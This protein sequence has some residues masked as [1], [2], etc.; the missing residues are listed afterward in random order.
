M[1][2]ISQSVIDKIKE[3]KITP[4]PRWGFLARNIS[5]WIFFAIS[6]IIGS[7]G[8]SALV[9]IMGISDWSVFGRLDGN[10]L[11]I[12]L[13]SMPYFWLVF[14]AVFLGAAY[15]NIFHTKTGY[16]YSMR[17]VAGLIAI[18]VTATGLMLYFLGGG[19]AVDNAF[20]ENIPAY[21]KMFFGQRILWMQPDKGLLAGEVKSM[22]SEKIFSLEDFDGID[23]KI[24]ITEDTEFFGGAEVGEGARL[25][26]VGA[27]KEPGVFEVTEIR[28]WMH[29][30]GC[31][32]HKMIGQCAM[33]K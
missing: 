31:R 22:E 20:S 15:F 2:D 27:K 26:L 19:K 29:G 10:Y 33:E 28:P 3:E 25:R 1:K 9:Y 32:I 24:V 23:W 16:R 17:S 13:L 6:L 8:L 12:I 18:T 4:K 7:L 14:L 11:R 21:E 30:A 5:Y